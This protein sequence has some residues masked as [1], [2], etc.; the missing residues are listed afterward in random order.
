MLAY[1]Q[2]RTM[3]RYLTYLQMLIAFVFYG[4]YFILPRVVK[5][6]QAFGKG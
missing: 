1:R 6:L 3:H 2:P 4:S 5:Q